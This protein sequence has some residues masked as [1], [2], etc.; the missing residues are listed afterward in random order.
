MADL[1]VAAATRLPWVTSQTVYRMC[2]LHAIRSVSSQKLTFEHVVRAGHSTTFQNA[3]IPR[4]Y[5]Q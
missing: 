3:V 1:T 2:V 5:E 4:K